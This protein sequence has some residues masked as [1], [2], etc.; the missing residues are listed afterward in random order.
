MTLSNLLYP[1][2]SNAPSFH[3][4]AL[5]ICHLFLDGKFRTGHILHDPGIF[6][7]Q[8]ILDIQSNCPHLI[9]W[10][11]TD[12]IQPFST[13]WPSN[14][15]T[16]NILQLIF[17]DPEHLPKNI[18]RLSKKLFV[19]YRLFVLL[20]CDDTKVQHQI[21][22]MSKVKVISN[23][24]S[25]IIYQSAKN[26]SVCV[27]SI[28]PDVKNGKEQQIGKVE[29]HFE[30][31]RV[32]NV[33]NENLFVS[34]F[35]KFEENSLMVINAFIPNAIKS[36]V[37]GIGMHEI[38]KK[39]HFSINFY[40]TS[41]D[42]AYINLT[43]RSWSSSVLHHDTILPRPQSVYKELSTEYDSLDAEKL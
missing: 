3:N 4:L 20:L 22:A 5:F 10:Q 38:S 15:S 33:K 25:L 18:V 21:S 43:T 9:P 28:T 32:T 7:N 24:N 16:D 41:L 8:L 29:P 19:F 39:L 17:F 36:N 6:D 26:G 27:Y 13:L 31:D 2:I 23:S 14:Q 12:I 1:N 35:G 37:S 34:T 40:Q 42:A 11:K 30:Q